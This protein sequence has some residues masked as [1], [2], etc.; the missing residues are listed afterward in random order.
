MYE[1]RLKWLK[2]FSSMK[3]PSAM[4][5][6]VPITT[7]SGS[8]ELNLVDKGKTSLDEARNLQEKLLSFKAGAR[9]AATDLVQDTP[10]FAVAS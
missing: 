9:V 6:V 1:K 3:H 10:L 7:S 2:L 8:L 5:R 4:W